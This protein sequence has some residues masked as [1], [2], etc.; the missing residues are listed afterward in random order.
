MNILSRMIIS[1]KKNCMLAEKHI[2]TLETEIYKHPKEKNS[3]IGK[4]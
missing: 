4:F 1:E 2:Q 3:P